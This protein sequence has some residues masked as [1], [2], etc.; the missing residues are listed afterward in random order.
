LVG[1]KSREGGKRGRMPNEVGE[2]RESEEGYPE[3]R[4]SKGEV[5][6]KHGERISN[7]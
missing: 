2:D 4:I 1:I 6:G 5:A 7:F 3:E